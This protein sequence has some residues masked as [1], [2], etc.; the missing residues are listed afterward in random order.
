MD[1]SAPTSIKLYEVRAFELVVIQKAYSFE[2]S[3]V[4]S[5]SA[6][7]NC[8]P[9]GVYRVLMT[10]QH[11]VKPSEEDVA[12]REVLQYSSIHSSP[13]YDADHGTSNAS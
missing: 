4:L 5:L 3:F 7:Y 10:I 12:M 2:S 8:V 13:S 9:L 1:H 6:P 11:V